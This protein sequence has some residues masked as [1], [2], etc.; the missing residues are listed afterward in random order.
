MDKTENSKLFVFACWS[1]TT[2]GIVIGSLGP[3][4]VP[5]S[6]TFHLRL[7]QMGLPIVSHSA[8]FL[9]GNIFLVV[10]WKTNRAR[11]FLGFSSL[12][13]SLSL[14]SI[15][16]VRTPWLLMVTLFFVGTSQGILHTSLD[17]LFSEVSGEERARPLNW[18]HIFFSTGAILGPLLVGTLLAHTER[19]NLVYLFIGLA[20]LPLSVLFW[21]SRLYRD[22]LS[23]GSTLAPVTHDLNKPA[24]SPLFWL[25]I[26]GMFLYV[27]L[28]LSFGSWTPVFLIRIRELPVVSASYSISVFWL[29]MVAGRF[30]FGRFFHKTNLSLSLVVGT[31]A[32]ALF[33]TL[34]FVL[35]HHVV[36]PLFIALSGLSLSW[37]YPTMIAL[38]ANTF[39][40]HIGFM[41]GILAASGT[42]GS[43]LFPWLIGPVSEALG[44][45][46]GVFVVPLLCVVLA[47]IF[48]SYAFLL[49]RT[50]Q[51][52]E[53][54][55]KDKTQSIHPR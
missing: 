33:T 22:S 52:I 12:V 16:L 28:E 10:L 50:K 3:L 29:T 51:K 36:I 35:S 53:G 19:W 47:G 34:T 48:S 11:L 44:L 49:K 6:D 43:I 38:G 45:A 8:G 30:L 23:S 15:S 37:F 5:I 42:S 31:L 55:N 54:H 40:K 20:S 7:A 27:G 9:G 24:A 4:L 32:A 39:P 26:G 13:A 17:C 46:R 14:T 2:V 21:R 18:L 25:A 41:T 1:M